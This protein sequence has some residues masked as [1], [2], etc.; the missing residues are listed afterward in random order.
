MRQE[1]EN[2]TIIH[3]LH[4]ISERRCH[5]FDVIEDVIP[6]YRVDVSL[7]TDKT[8]KTIKTAPQGEVLEFSVEGDRVNIHVPEI[9]GHQ[10]IAVEFA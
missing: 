7:R 5:V 1:A 6:F 8:V 3:L 9:N 10:M 2:R 4:Y